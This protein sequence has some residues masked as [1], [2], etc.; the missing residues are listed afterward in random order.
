MSTCSS[1]TPRTQSLTVDY[2]SR[3]GRGKW[4]VL[5]QAELSSA[6]QGENFWKSA[7]QLRVPVASITVLRI[8]SDYAGRVRG[9]FTPAHFT[10]YLDHKPCICGASDKTQTAQNMCG[11]PF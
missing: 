10:V 4:R 1:Q 5:R 6:L 7:V 8:L 2:R 11:E 9:V 3:E